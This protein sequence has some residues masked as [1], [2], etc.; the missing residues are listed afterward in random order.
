MSARDRFVAHDRVRIRPRGVVVGDIAVLVKWGLARM[1]IAP[2][3]PLKPWNEL[4]RLYARGGWAG[5][6]ECSHDDR[7]TVR[8]PQF[9]K[10]LRGNATDVLKG[11]T[12][13]RRERHQLARDNADV[14]LWR[15]NRQFR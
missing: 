4:M 12:D 2:T 15:D 3:S 10:W 8:L 13:I 14:N 5:V 11:E 9:L 1:G 6:L 7:L